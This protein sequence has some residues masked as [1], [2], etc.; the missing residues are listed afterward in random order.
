MHQPYKESSHQ[1]G[2]VCNKWTRCMLGWVK[3]VNC[4]LA[5]LVAA[6]TDAQINRDRQRALNKALWAKEIGA[7][8]RKPQPSRRK[9]RALWLGTSAVHESNTS[10]CFISLC[11]LNDHLLICPPPC[12][13][14]PL[15]VLWMVRT[16]QPKSTSPSLAQWWS[17]WKL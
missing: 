16:Q 8:D 2:T 12:Q 11:S 3:M 15:N 7:W 4:D 1:V 13:V 9:A 5:L 10:S 17:T 6:P 14:P